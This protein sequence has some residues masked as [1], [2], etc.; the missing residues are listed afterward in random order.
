MATPSR[1]VAGLRPRHRRPPS[2]LASVPEMSAGGAGQTE[3]IVNKHPL[4]AGS[5]NRRVGK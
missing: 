3:A 1:N 4:R 2:L 5:R